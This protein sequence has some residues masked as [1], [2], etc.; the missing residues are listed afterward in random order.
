MHRNVRALSRG[1]A[2]IG[3]GFNAGSGPSGERCAT[4]QADRT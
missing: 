4:C 3:E 1:L 2:L